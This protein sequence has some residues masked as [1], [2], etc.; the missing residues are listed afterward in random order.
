MDARALEGG[1]AD[2][3]I[4]A[5]LAFRAVLEAMS[6]PGSVQQA[7]GSR[8]PKPLGIAAGAV[9]LTL[10]DHDT[11]IWLAPELAGQDVRDW[12]AFHTG[13]PLVDRPA[14]RFAF[15]SWE[16]MR[17][18]S[19]FAIGSSEYPDRSATLVVEVADLGVQHRLTG[20]GIQTFAQ[21]TVPDPA[22]FAENHVLFPLGWDAILTCGDRIVGLPRTTRVEV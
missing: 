20:P 22:V 13:A 7:A 12:F 17:P 18:V 3:A 9:A 11:S 16:A 21:A 15:G 1:F 8:P 10:C 6:R 14:A 19:D 4:G 2:P 5:A